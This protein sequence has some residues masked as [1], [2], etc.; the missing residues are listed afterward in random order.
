MGLGVQ[1]TP[2]RSAPVSRRVQGWGPSGGDVAA[3]RAAHSCK[4]RSQFPAFHSNFLQLQWL[5]AALLIV[6]KY[7]GSLAQNRKQRNL[8]SSINYNKHLQAEKL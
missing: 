6:N 5:Q 3:G 2:R 7:K 4:V 1:A 8:P